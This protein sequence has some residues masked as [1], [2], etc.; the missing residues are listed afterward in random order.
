MDDLTPIRNC[1][2]RF[3]FRCPKKWE[4]LDITRDPAVRH[5]SAC[6]QRVY[7][8]RTE[9]ETRLHAK[10]RH[11]VAVPVE[12]KTEEITELICGGI[13]EEIEDR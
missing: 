7:L 2:I 6:D 1:G 8:C 13:S 5:C 3:T 11:C 4:H 12:K 10:A 9:E